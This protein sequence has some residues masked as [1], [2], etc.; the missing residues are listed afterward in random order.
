VGGTFLEQRFSYL[1]E[2]KTTMMA[3]EII[4]GKRYMLV[5]QL[6]KLGFQNMIQ[7][8]LYGYGNSFKYFLQHIS[9]GKANSARKLAI[10]DVLTPYE[11]RRIGCFKN[12]I[13]SYSDFNSVRGFINHCNIESIDFFKYIVTHHGGEHFASYGSHFMGAIEDISSR[14]PKK[15]MQNLAKKIQ[16]QFCSIVLDGNQGRRYGNVKS[17][18]WHLL[19]D[20]YSMYEQLY[21]N[22]I[23]LYGKLSQFTRTTNATAIRETHDQL[24]Y[25]CKFKDYPPERFTSVCEQYKKFEY[26][27]SD[28]LIRLPLHGGEVVSEGSKM[29]HCVGGY[30]SRIMQKK[31]VILFMRRKNNPDKE[32]ATIELN[33]HGELLQVKCKFNQVITSAG[34][35]DFLTKWTTAKKIRIQTSDISVSNG[36]CDVSYHHYAGYYIEKDSVVDANGKRKKKS[37]VA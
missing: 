14:I 1:A 19:R 9:N 22:D 36:C 8:V 20:V 32:Y 6:E 7:D 25:L 23:E 17:N 31:S 34:A 27:D 2:R 35:L 5:E 29:G 12:S 15:Q 11:L 24:S 4:I 13:K 26:E 30:V 18:V 21:D 16:K 3:Y 33:L 28:F 10:N 37:A